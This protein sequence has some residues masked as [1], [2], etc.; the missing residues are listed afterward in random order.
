MVRGNMGGNEEPH[1]RVRGVREGMVTL[2]SIPSAG[3]GF[4]AFSAG[5]HNIRRPPFV[6]G[7]AFLDCIQV[8][9]FDQ[10]VRGIV[11]HFL[12]DTASYNDSDMG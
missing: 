10:D 8:Q 7:I 11:G 1:A 4:K 5:D 2:W 9:E 3:V 6:R 12:N